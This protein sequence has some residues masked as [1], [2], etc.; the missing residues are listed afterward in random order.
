VNV[1]RFRAPA[2]TSPLRSVIAGLLLAASASA[3]LPAT[4]I[5]APPQVTV[6]KPAAALPGA[7]YAWVP[8]PAPLAVEADPRVQD[9]QFRA[10]L[11]AA[12]DKAL[13]AKGYQPAGA[14]A[15]A[16]F[17]I[18]YRVGVRDLEQTLVKET[19]ASP[20]TPEATFECGGDGCS[21][22]VTR[23][24]GGVPVLKTTTEQQVEGGLLIEILEP[25]SIRVVW[26]ALNRGTVKR[27]DVGKVQLE[28]VARNTLA[29]L[30]N[31]QP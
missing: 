10:R 13:Q 22:L 7:R 25:D 8:M 28:T 2:P 19:G 1:T 24:T 23:G 3:L 17:F 5:A 15:Q 18:A 30:P 14:L 31:A 20:A 12:L 4:A 29:Q 27:K 26:R 21:Q 11:Q 9:P 6:L 16:D